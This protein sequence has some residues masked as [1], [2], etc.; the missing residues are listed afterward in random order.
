MS[1]QKNPI[2]D[3]SSGSYVRKEGTSMSDAIAKLRF[4]L[5]AAH[6]QITEWADRAN[7][8]CDQR[9]AALQQRDA[10]KAELLALRSKPNPDPSK[11]LHCNCP[12]CVC[13]LDVVEDEHG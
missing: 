5:T 9:N 12:S 11:R 6:S 2:S 10:L 4:E 1:M 7:D 3:P 8:M 13:L